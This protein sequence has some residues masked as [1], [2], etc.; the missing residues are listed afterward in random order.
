MPGCSRTAH[1]RGRRSAP[2]RARRPAQRV[3]A[4][5]RGALGRGTAG[6]RPR[7]GARWP[8]AAHRKRPTGRSGSSRSARVAGRRTRP[9]ASQERPSPARPSPALSRA[10]RAAEP[11][12]AA[13]PGRSRARPAAPSSPSASTTRVSACGRRS[14]RAGPKRRSPTPAAAAAGAR[15][16]DDERT[17]RA[18]LAPIW[19]SLARTD[20]VTAGR[21]LVELLPAQREAYPQRVAYDLAFGEGR[22]CAQVTVGDGPPAIRHADEPRRAGEVDFQ[23]FG[24]PAE[25]ARM[26]TAGA[27]RRRFG[28][29]VARVRAPRPRGGVAL[30]ARGEARPAR[31]TPDRGALG[32][33]AGAAAGGVDDRP[34]LDGARAVCGRLCRRGGA[35]PISARP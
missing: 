32:A 17:G 29:G 23:V 35:D 9:G 18:W 33:R 5:A 14:R 20:P 4:R 2:P 12:G 26:L 28:R 7:Q 21:L 24:S 30:A 34:I 22:G 1:L 13:A 3:R 31:P 6:R 25:I 16:P 10:R 8:S 19:S 11:A 15:I 27:F